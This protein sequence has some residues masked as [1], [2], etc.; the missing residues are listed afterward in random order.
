LVFGE[1]RLEIA[2]I[3]NSWRVPAGPVFQVRTLSDQ[4]FELFYDQSSE[5]WNAKT[6]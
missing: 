3:L 2:E 6:I 4:T 1:A 5:Q